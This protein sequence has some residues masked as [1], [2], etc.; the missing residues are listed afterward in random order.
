MIFILKTS[1]YERIHQVMERKPTLTD[2]A[3]TIGNEFNVRLSYF[4]NSSDLDPK[5]SFAFAGNYRVNLLRLGIGVA[6]L[7]GSV[8]SAVASS[9]EKKNKNKNGSH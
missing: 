1:L 5:M 9:K 6:L 3:P 4:S 7:V 2:R 8:A